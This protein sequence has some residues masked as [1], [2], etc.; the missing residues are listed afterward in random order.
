MQFTLSKTDLSDLMAQIQSVVP[1]KPT[2][3]ILSNFMLKA[4][5]EGLELTATDLTVGIRCFVKAPVTAGG[6][7]TIPSRRFFQLVRE[8]TSPSI[9]VHV[10]ESDICEIK[11]ASSHFKLN[12]MS[13]NDY[14]QLPNLNEAMRLELPKEE[15]KAMLSKTAFAVSKDES[16]YLM[17]GILLKV[18]SGSMT[19]VGTDARRLAKVE[20]KVDIDPAFSG[21]YIIP[22]KA[23]DEISRLLDRS[24]SESVLL[25]LAGDRIGI[26][27]NNV[28]LVTKLLV[29]TFP[30]FKS[31]IPASHAFE[32]DLHREELV[33]M[34]RQIMVFADDA[35]SSCLLRFTDSELVLTSAHHQIGEGTTSM[36]VNYHGELF[37]IAFNPLHLLDV[38]KHT[39]G[40]MLRL[41]L[42]DAFSP[43]VAVPAEKKE[44]DLDTL[45][46]IMPMRK[47]T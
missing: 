41:R 28:L 2:L 19:F 21:E 9:E 12:G 38:L 44:D 3:P 43:A 36:P 15:L 18:E 25:Y 16:R 40:E 39:S 24:S 27:T 5:S 11:S 30:D 8:M 7:T 29:G 42:I 6:S 1:S 22:L 33:S 47:A 35:A 17:T 23:V 10:G 45:F 26:E 13:G 4:S 37:E 46:V 34:L 31:V 14:P 20:R 32:V